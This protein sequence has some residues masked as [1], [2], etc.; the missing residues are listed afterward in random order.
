MK[1]EEFTKEASPPRSLVE[2]SE[3]HEHEL[4][5][6]DRTEE[7]RIVRKLD[8]CLIPLMTMFYLLS[9][10]DRANIGNARVAGLQKDLGL[11]DHQ[12]QVC[13]TVLYVP[14]I[15]AELPS[16]LLLRKIGPR[17]VMPTILTLW[18]TICALQAASLSGAFSGLLAAAIEHMHGIDG[19]PG[20]AWI[21]ILEGIFSVIV[22]LISFFI[23]PSTPQ[24]V[25]WLTQRE[26][27]IVIKRLLRD[28]PTTSPL[29][30]FSFVQVWRSMSSP[31][32][33]LNFIALFMNGTTLYGLALFLPSIV[34]Q[35]GYSQTHTQLISVGP[36][37]AGFAVTLITSYLSDHFKKRATFAV[38]NSLIAMTG[39][40]VQVHVLRLLVPLRVRDLRATSDSLSMDGEQLGAA[41]SEGDERRTGI[42]RNQLGRDP[43]HVDVPVQGGSALQAGNE[44]RHQL[45]RP[46]PSP[47]SI[48]SP[49]NSRSNTP[50]SPKHSSVGILV[51]SMLNILYLTHATR[52]KHARRAQLLAPYVKNA[53]PAAPLDGGDT[54]WAELGDRH[55]DFRYAL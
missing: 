42:R 13:V 23:T 21:F 30:T 6:F 44:S 31:H 39:L 5:E 8:F 53:D 17:I 41:L 50:P 26:K 40:D 29:D 19:R 33:I 48:S 49:S 45:V 46:I 25:R 16:N 32:V 37:A 4:L 52:Q 55:P 2:E 54:A 9:F 12:Y 27:E 35:L 43:E 24:D 18:G 11:T 22:G 7:R 47:S 34:N 28:R 20:W 38:V 51:F 14:Y 15:A 3:S 10:L 1:S 36:F